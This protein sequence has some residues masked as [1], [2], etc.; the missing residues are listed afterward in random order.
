MKDLII[1]LLIVSALI[2]GWLCF[3]NYSHKES[4]SLSNY[5]EEVIIPL[6]EEEKWE[7]VGELYNSFEERWRKYQN[8]A[9]SFLENE[10]LS[11]IDLCVA[12]AEKYIE[13]KDVSNSAGEICSIATQLQLL[14]KREKV[15]L[16][17]IL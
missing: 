1:S 15:T 12:R 17:N 6:T 8:V 14:D 9:L 7:E 5:L 16:A 2:G 11:E 10:Q 3:D 4:Y 13:A